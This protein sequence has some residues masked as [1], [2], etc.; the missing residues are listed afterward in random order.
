MTTSQ[1]AAPRRAPRIVAL[2]R[3][4][5]AGLCEVRSVKNDV[6]YNSQEWWNQ[7]SQSVQSAAAYDGSSG[8][9]ALAAF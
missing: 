1:Q 6:R 9:K 5:L 8:T 7:A 2:T 4:H 3:P